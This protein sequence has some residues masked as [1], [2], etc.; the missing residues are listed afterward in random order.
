MLNLRFYCYIICLNFKKH[1][2][3]GYIVMLERLSN[4]WDL[5]RSIF[6]DTS[7]AMERVQAVKEHINPQA[8]IR[9]D[10]LFQA[11]VSDITSPFAH[12]FV[13][14]HQRAIEAM[15][16]SQAHGYVQAA[17]QPID[18]QA[19]DLGVLIRSERTTEAVGSMQLK[20]VGDLMG[21]EIHG[22]LRTVT[23]NEPEEAVFRYARLGDWVKHWENFTPL[24][25]LHAV[26][27]GLVLAGQ[28]NQAIEFWQKIADLPN[29]AGL[30]EHS[31]EFDDTSG[32]HGQKSSYDN[33]GVV[34][35]PKAEDPIGRSAPG[36]VHSV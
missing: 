28:E 29:H 25:N 3:N 17:I 22:A 7:E 2:L 32:K 4:A 14:Q 31:F 21:Y 1:I 8:I 35:E 12:F 5:G 11:F 13:Q 20:L 19:D 10:Q 16:T 27:R 18:P 9:E 23:S 26:N 6:V 34:V 30:F 24:S 15:R 33:W 36:L